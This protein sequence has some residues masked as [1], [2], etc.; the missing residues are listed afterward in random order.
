MKQQLDD[1]K[2]Q[3]KTY[4]GLIALLDSFKKGEESR[5][6]ADLNETHKGDDGV[7]GGHEHNGDNGFLLFGVAPMPQMRAD[8][9]CAEQHGENRARTCA[10]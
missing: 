8:E 6:A 9:L 7:E 10:Q 1:K 4:Q 5:A 2:W 3:S